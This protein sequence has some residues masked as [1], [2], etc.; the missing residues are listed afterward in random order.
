MDKEPTRAIVLDV[1]ESELTRFKDFLESFGHTKYIVHDAAPIYRD[2]IMSDMIINRLHELDFLDTLNLDDYITSGA[3]VKIGPREEEKMYLDFKTEQP[4]EPKTVQWLTPIFLLNNLTATGYW[5]M[6]A[7]VEEFQVSGL[8]DLDEHLEL[9][10][11]L[12]V[13]L[14]NNIDPKDNEPYNAMMALLVDVFSNKK[15][16]LG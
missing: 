6:K 11:R 10:D 14:K 15:I 7:W 2:M 4:I 9:R 16:R 1:P 5:Q 12:Y 3:V 8:P 13:L